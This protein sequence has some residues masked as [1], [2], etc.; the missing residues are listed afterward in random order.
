MT[1]SQA[2]AAWPTLEKV[3]ND[4]DLKIVGPAVNY[5]G[6]CVSENGTTY[7]NPFDYLDD[8]FTACTDCQIDYIGLHWYGG[9]NSIVNYVNT[10][11]KYN[12]PIW[13]TEFAAWDGSVKTPGDQQKYLAGTVNF[14]ERDPDV[15]RY[16][17]FIGRTTNGPNSN[18]YIDL[19]GAD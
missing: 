8:F 12:K 16:S 10:A 15:Y 6:E 13:V 19:Y 5:C 1:P 11:R 2:A 3:A 17:W 18:H 14:L 4:N 7:Y 9:G